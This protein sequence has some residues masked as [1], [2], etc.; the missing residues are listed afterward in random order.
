[1]GIVAGAFCAWAVGV[2]YRMGY[3]DSL[4]V[5]GVHF[6]GGIVGTLMIGLLATQANVE[7]LGFGSAGLFY[8]GGTTQLGKQLVAV[9]AVMIFAFAVTWVIAKLIDM[10]IGFRIDEDIEV[11]GIDQA[12]HLETAYDNIGGG[13]TF[14]TGA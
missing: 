3:D 12:E 13:S 8:G 4:D 9:V 7:N 11:S 1:V 5:V 6:G 2:K 10:T 14:S